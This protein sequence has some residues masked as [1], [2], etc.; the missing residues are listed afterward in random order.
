MTL[1]KNNISIL[2]RNQNIMQAEL[3]LMLKMSRRYLG[4]LERGERQINQATIVKI[5]NALKVNTI[6]ILSIQKTN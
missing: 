3:A 2:R 4:L 1:Y 5:A 6:D